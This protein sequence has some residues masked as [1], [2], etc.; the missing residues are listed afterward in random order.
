MPEPVRIGAIHDACAEREQS[1]GWRG[2]PG[3]LRLFGRRVGAQSLMRPRSIPA[4]SA[5]P[6]CNVPPQRMA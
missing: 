2:T 1:A 6:A 4:K 3:G 5:K